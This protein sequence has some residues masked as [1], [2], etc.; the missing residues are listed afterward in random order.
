VIYLSTHGYDRAVLLIP[1]WF[2]LVVWAV[3]LVLTVMGFVVNDIIGPALL[4]G[5]VLIVM[6][7]GFTVMQHAFAGGITHNIVTDVERRALALTGAGDMIWDWDV[8]ADRIY[9]SPETEHLLGLKRGALEGPASRWLDVL[10]AL[11]RDRFR[12]ALD[13]VL[14][15]RR[16]RLVQDFRLRTPEGHYL[17]F[18]LKA[19][20]VVGSD[21][22]VVRLVGTLTDVTEFKTAEERLLHDAVH[23]NL[24]GLP[25]RQLFLDRLESVMSFAKADPSVRATVVVIDLDRF[26]QVNDSV[27]IAVG[28]S[29]L[30][31]LARRLARLLKPQDTLARL[32]GDQFSM[33]VLSEKDPTR[34]IA[35]AETI[36]RTIRAPI[37]FNDREI[38]LTASIGLALGDQQPN[39]SE[40]VLKDAELAMYHAKRIGGDRIEVFKPPMRARKTDRLTLESELR[41]A[42][43][44]EEIIILYQPIVRLED[45]SVAG[46]EALARWEH[47]KMGRMSPSEFISIAEEIGLIVDL[48]LFVLERTARQLSSWQRQVRLREPVFASVNVS[49]RQ[50]LR[51]DLIHDLRTVLSR[52]GLAR[53][54]LKLELTESLVMENPEHAAQLL[55]RIR[56][57]GAGLALDDFGTGHSSLAYLQRFPFDTIKIDQS[58]VRA[59]NKGTR[60]VLL[61]SIISLAHDLGMD[62]V[63]EGAETDS[64]AVELYQ[65]GCEYAQGFVFGEPMT[66]EAAR[67][68]LMNE[69]MEMAR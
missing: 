64:D 27:G 48:G 39:R 17:W 31:T 37:T 43:E 44:R 42:L 40:E 46:F 54:T 8:S 41:R 33:I 34:L 26:K 35:F 3:A 49:S 18:A 20:P 4:G 5:L 32:T 36:R 19:R 58:F 7:I 12:A 63:A 47:P 16:G 38:F 10:H 61:R 52:A 65:L 56:E 2:L 28:D 51:H 1:T 11:D 67:K 62:V 21:G 53:G 25:N 57:L 60:P 24:T 55:T 14:E 9:T 69:Q 29:I 50:L 59:N 30:L 13:S 23:D 45:R 66:A 68:M 22:E 15:Q 6:L